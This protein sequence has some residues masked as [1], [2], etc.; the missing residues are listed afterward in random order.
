MTRPPGQA[1]VR[2]SLADAV[3]EHVRAGD[4]LHLMVGHSRWSAAAREV[5]RQWWERDPHFT[6][7][8][9]SLSSLGALFF[10]GGLVDKVI[11][12]YSG[13]TFPNFTPNPHFAG[14][15][16]RGEV[17]VEHWSFLAFSQRLEAA[18]RGLPAIVTRSIGGSAM[19]DNDGYARVETPFGEV[20]LLEPLAA[21][22]ALLHA[23]VADR[24]G[25]VAM[26]PPLLEGVWGALGARRGAIVT[27]ERIVDD[28]TPWSHLVRIPAHRVLAVVETPL[29]AH[30][31]GLYPGDLPVAGYGEDYE[32][33]VAARNA[34]RA[35]D[36]DGWI[37]H[38][39][40]E[41]ATQDEY[42]ER[43]GAERRAELV[44]RAAP[45]SW[46][47]DVAAF[48]A[49]LDAPPNAWERAAT[50][51]A[52]H[53]ARRITALG[54]DAVLAGAGVANLAAWL[55]VGLARQAGSTV[56]LTAEIG[57]WGY[58][59]VR[60]DP[61]VLNHQNFPS[62][63]MLGDAE[64]VLGAL[65]GGAG[66][67]TIACLGGAQVD[68]FGNINSTEIPDGPFLVGSGGGNDVAAVCEEAIVVAKLAP[69]RTPPDCG[70]V[71][72]PGRAVQALVTDLGTFE[73]PVPLA[74][75]TFVLTAL[76]PGVAVADVRAACGWEIDVADSLT[77]SD[78][79]TE[80][81]IT[82]LR[83]W[84]PRAWFLRD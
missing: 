49:D 64:L 17:E 75:S 15:Y 42:L 58:D 34:T 23:A 13:D 72:S 29:G 7:V 61:F 67:T 30:P 6:L 76:A 3:A 78:P 48:P 73:K 1:Q 45:D 39:V 50:F 40:L 10:R 22:V 27:V 9:A 77:V 31:G 8:M 52:R 82:S 16:R 79:P 33:W 43:L 62:A 74:D 36:Y 35:D 56:E 55:G 11:T 20:G 80:E 57:L 28:L 32:F 2:A 53:L 24:D 83:R 25:N 51:G 47:A 41:P 69:A 65:V 37:R 81:E 44:A 5:V 14:A 26:H 46:R 54:A 70:Y 63:T 60:G 21:D 59:A 12:G 66:T 71:T 68:R 84:D 19:E 38:W 4:V 18:A